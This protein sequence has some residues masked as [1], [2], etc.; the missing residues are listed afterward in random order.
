[1]SSK[2][3]TLAEKRKAAKNTAAETPSKRHKNEHTPESPSKLLRNAT[4]SSSPVKTL[5]NFNGNPPEISNDTLL[6]PDILKL[7]PQIHVNP[8][9]VSS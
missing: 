9:C 5:I 3:L 4:S 8:I 6:H 1:M 2:R 7:F